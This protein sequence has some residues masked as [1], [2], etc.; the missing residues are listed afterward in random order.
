MTFSYDDATREAYAAAPTDTVVLNTLEFLHPTF[1]EPLRVVIN[2]E[3]ITGTLEVDAPAGA[4]Q[5]VVFVAIAA[6]IELPEVGSGSHEMSIQMDNVSGQ[7]NEA[8]A[9]ASAS[10]IKTTVVYR[11]AR[12]VDGVVSL[13]MRWVLTLT[14]A[15]ANVYT[16]KATTSFGDTVNWPFPGKDYTATDYPGLAE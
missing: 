10:T 7:I 12:V 16:A 11:G 4:G 15:R 2:T 1:T 5:S 8:L 6:Q 14:E 3:S 13:G 9:L